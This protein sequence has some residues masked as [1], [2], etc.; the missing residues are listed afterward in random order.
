VVSGQPGTCVP[1]RVNVLMFQAVA[2]AAASLLSVPIHKFLQ[3]WALDPVYLFL[4]WR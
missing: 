4:D 2:T 3:S 1:P